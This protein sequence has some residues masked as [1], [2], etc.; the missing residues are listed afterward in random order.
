[1]TLGET[2]AANGIANTLNSVESNFGMDFAGAALDPDSAVSASGIGWSIVGSM[3]PAGAGLL[4]SIFKRVKFIKDAKAGAGYVRVIEGA[5]EH[6]VDSATHIAET[7]GARVLH[8]GNA[9]DPDL[10]INGNLWELKRIGGQEKI[11]STRPFVG[12]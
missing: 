10:I 12:R 5:A 4:R 8:R 11:F 9:K 2:S 3:L 7:L 1:M 6:E